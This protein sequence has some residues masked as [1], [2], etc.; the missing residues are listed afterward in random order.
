MKFIIFIFIFLPLVFADDMVVDKTTGHLVPKYVGELKAFKGKV[1]KKVSGDRLAPLTPG[2]R[3]F[4]DDTLVTQEKSFAKLLIVDETVMTVGPNSEVNFSEFKFI[5]KGDRK[6]HY[7]LLKGQLRGEVKNKAKE[8][9]VIIKTK[10]AVLGV[11]GTKILANFRKVNELEISEFAL[12]SGSANVT[13]LLTNK[14]YE[15]D[16]EDRIIVINDMNKS[17]GDKNKVKIDDLNILKDAEEFLPYYLLE[18]V[19]STSPLFDIVNNSLQAN[20]NSINEVNSAENRPTSEPKGSFH[21]LQK[22]NEKLKE[23]QKKFR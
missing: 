14:N 7:T 9:E 13:N 17:A 6:I 3:L 8:D 11:R 4:K 16:K 2:T 12:E 23:N 21:N 5:S 1:F 18:Q 15:I 19:K 10:N 22:L 20:N